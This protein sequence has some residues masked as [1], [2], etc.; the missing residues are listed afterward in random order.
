MRVSDAG[1]A[2][3]G[4]FAVVRVQALA[5]QILLLGGEAAQVLD[6]P[7]LLLLVFGVRVVQSRSVVPPSAI[8]GCRSCGGARRVVLPLGWCNDLRCCCSHRRTA[9]VPAFSARRSVSL[10]HPRPC[11]SASA[12]TSHRTLYP[13]P[14]PRSQP[15]LLL[16][17]R[18]SP[19][20]PT[21]QG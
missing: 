14:A 13:V 1:N 15:P 2:P 21:V 3:D 7:D 10:A 4:L 18:W 8:G 11:R 16:G 5:D 17:D 20:S 19:M 9:N 6:D 12:A